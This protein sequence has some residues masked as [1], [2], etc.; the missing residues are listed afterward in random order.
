MSYIKSLKGVSQ[1]IRPINIML[2]FDLLIIFFSCSMVYSIPR[3]RFRQLPEISQKHDMD[4]L[5][6]DEQDRELE[7]TQ[8]IYPLVKRKDLS[9][10]ELLDYLLRSLPRK[11]YNR[12]H[13]R[14][15]HFGLSR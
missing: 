14:G 6:E 2:T 4:N 9:A 8:D 15:Q 1:K 7:L 3:S 13:V 5:W 10:V 11:T 12:N